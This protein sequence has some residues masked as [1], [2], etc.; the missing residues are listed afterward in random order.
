MVTTR[1]QTKKIQKYSVITDFDAS[2]SAWRHN[3]KCLKFGYFVY[4]CGYPCK[5]GKSCQKRPLKSKKRCSIH[6]YYN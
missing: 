1:S 5:D 2:S 4:V 6:K 3:K